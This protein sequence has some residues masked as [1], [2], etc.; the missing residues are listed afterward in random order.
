MLPRIANK[1]SDNYNYYCI[2]SD[3]HD[4]SNNYSE[5]KVL[6]SHLRAGIEM[7]V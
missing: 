6:T 1:I 7:L 4:V 3:A 2:Y 5:I